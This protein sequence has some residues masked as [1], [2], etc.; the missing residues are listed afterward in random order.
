MRYLRSRIVSSD[1]RGPV[2]ESPCNRVCTLD[3]VSGLCLGC[4]RS[5]DEIARWTQ[6]SDAERAQV[7]AD[8]GGRPAPQ[9]RTSV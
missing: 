1:R 6:M 8:L 2:I 3:P 4:G 7:V 9:R 5:L